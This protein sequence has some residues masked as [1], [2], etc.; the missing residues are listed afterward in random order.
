MSLQTGAISADV[1]HKA[2]VDQQANF[3]SST[4]SPSWGISCFDSYSHS[5]G[6]I[7]LQFKSTKFPSGV[8][9]FRK[10]Y[11]IWLLAKTLSLLAKIFIHLEVSP[12]PTYES[13]QIWKIAEKMRNVA[14]NPP[15]KKKIKKSDGQTEGSEM[16]TR[17]GCRFLPA[18]WERG[19]C[20]EK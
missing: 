10:H 20:H 8:C 15:C 19:T 16:Q 2:S 12:L 3:M 11:K 6:N 9:G 18:V 1:F 17:L 5:S 13:L 4:F 14:K 7:F